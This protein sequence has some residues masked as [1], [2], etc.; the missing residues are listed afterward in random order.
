M[1]SVF[2]RG[3][4]ANRR[5]Y[6]YVSWNDHQGRRSTECTRTTDKATAE[7]I[8]A[9]YEADAA[10]R[11]DGVIDPALDTISKESQRTIESH[12]TDFESKLRVA[13]RTD[14]YVNRTIGFIRSICQL[15]EFVLVSDISAEGVNRYAGDL[16]NKGRSARTIQA[17][18]TAIK[19]FTKWLADNHKLPRNPLASVRK[20]NP[21][22]DRRYERRM[23]LPEEWQWLRS[24]TTCG[25]VRYGMTGRERVL[26][27]TTAIQTGLRAGELRSR[28]RGK[29]FLDADRPHIVCQAGS[30]KSKKI[31]RQYVDA[32][33][34]RDLR[35]HVATKAP[36]A[37]V[38]SLPSEFDMADMIR[39]DLADARRAWIKAAKQNPKEHQKR[40]QSDFLSERSHEGEVIDFHALRHTCGAWLAKAGVHPKV[41]QV[42]MRHSSITLT[43]DHYGHLFEGQEA[44][45]VQEL[46][47]LLVTDDLEVLQATGTDDQHGSNG[48]A[49]DNSVR[50]DAPQT[51]SPQA[52]AREENKAQRQAQRAGRESVQTDAAVCEEMEESETK[53]SSPKSLPIAG[54]CGG[55]QHYATVNE[56]RPGGIR[57][58]D[59]GIMSP[60]L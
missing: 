30:T 60:L 51:V 28:T 54:L 50:S 21:K 33:L 32:A 37:K 53:D 42:V 14:D 49:G 9:K 31:A 36:Q 45:A 26:L 8:V 16:Q 10:L 11:R 41:V 27:Y 40:A 3:G 39:D 24:I 58:P 22:V 35:S 29:L 23:L 47:H 5:G 7:R 43:Y 18:L 34:A 48:S 59:Q 13:G 6:Y 46:S 1:A 25:P 44:D 52:L 12:L 17:H 55:V 56:S 15:A 38:F 19:G 20:P 4:K 2:K 57:T